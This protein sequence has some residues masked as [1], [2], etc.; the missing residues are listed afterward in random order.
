MCFRTILA[1]LNETAN[2]LAVAA[3]ASTLAC[4]FEA[5]LTGLYVIPAAPI[6][7][8]AHYEPIPELFEAHRKHF[9]RQSHSVRAAFKAT[10]LNNTLRHQLRIENSP[11]PLI[12]DCVIEQGRSFDLILVSQTETASKLGVELDFVPRVAVAVGRPVMVIPFNAPLESIPE[13]VIIGWN[14]SREAARA[15]FDSLPIL[16][17]AT[18][19]HIVWIDPPAERQKSEAIP[20]ERIARSLESQGIKVVVDPVNSGADSTGDALLKKAADLRAGMLV[21]G[22]YGRSRL[23]EFVLGGVTRTVMQKMRCPVLLSH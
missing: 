2:N 5:H 19:I 17:R 16:K 6:Y 4:E 18:K 22:A 21:I 9:N 11:S 1:C 7:P 23:S 20:G 12:G 14:G 15:V 13:T 3:T 10:F 8:S